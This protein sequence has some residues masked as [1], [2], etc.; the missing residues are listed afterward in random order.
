MNFVVAHERLGVIR[1][2]HLQPDSHSRVTPHELMQAIVEVA[3]DEGFADGEIDIAGAGALELLEPRQEDL[4]LSA[5]LPI[6]GTRSFT[7]LGKLDL[8]AAALDQPDAQVFLESRDLAA[9]G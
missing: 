2:T 3:G 6:V 4:L 1:A 7:G 5:R 9:A 8:A